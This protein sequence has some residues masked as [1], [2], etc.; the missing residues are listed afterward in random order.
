MCARFLFKKIM[1][2]IITKEEAFKRAKKALDVLKKD[3]ILDRLVPGKVIDV[4]SKECTVTLEYVL[5]DDCTN[6][7]G[8]SHGGATAW[9]CDLCMAVAIST[10]GG[11]V[12]GTTID[13]TVN[14]IEPI[15]LNQPIRV[16]T[17][18]TKIGGFIRRGESSVYVGSK[19]AATSVGN[20][21]GIKMAGEQVIKV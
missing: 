12:H 21:T 16:V 6:P 15:P 1:N 17:K 19:L 13:M 11:A 5:P 10:Y 9:L 7:W 14:Y 2:D 3:F 20:Y 8:I 4:D 18:C